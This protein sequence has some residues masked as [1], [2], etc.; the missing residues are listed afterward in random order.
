ML[1]QITWNQFL[2]VMAV[3]LVAWYGT[4]LLACYGGELRSWIMRKADRVRSNGDSGAPVEGHAGEL[5]HVAADLRGILEKAGKEA[6]RQQLLSQLS[7]RLANYAGLRQPAFRVALINLI[8]R[9]AERLC[10]TR[11]SQQEIARALEELSP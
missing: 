8:I 5:E 9:E 10:D 1:D 3:A 4:V 7:A 11:Y 6:G 2:A